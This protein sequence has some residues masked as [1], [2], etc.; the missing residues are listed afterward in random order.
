MK[1]ETIFLVALLGVLLLWPAAIARGDEI[2]DLKQQL[3]AQN[4]VLTE[5]QERIAQL[6]ARQKL[7]EQALTQKIDE[8]AQIA[9]K[10]EAITLPDS[11]KWAEKVKISGD[12]RYR[13]E[14]I[15]AE[16]NG[17]YQPGNNRNRI[18]ARLMLESIINDEW[19]VGFRIATGSSS[20]PATTNQNLDNG[21]TKKDIWLDL[22]YFDWHPKAI[23]RLNVF[24]GKML[25]PFY[26]AGNNQ[27]IWDD[28]V[29][30]EGIAAKYVIPFTKSDNL[31]VNGG[32]LWLKEDVGSAGGAGLWGAQTYLKHEFESKNY[33]LGG[34][35]FYAF[36]GLE[37]KSTLFSDSKGFGNTVETVGGKTFYTMDY[38]VFEG[39]GEYG[40]KIC[41]L[42]TTVYGNYVKNTSANTSE[43][44]GWLIGA[45]FNKAKDAGSWEL[46]Y[47]YRD[48]EKDAVLG[49]LTDS[50]FIGGGT[51]GKGH[52]F[53]GKYQLTKNIQAAL[54]YFLSE[55]LTNGSSYEKCD[56]YH[57]LMADLV[58]KF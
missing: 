9:E 22:A 21:F 8:V 18:R 27:L 44:A 49:V 30:P 40:F 39:F 41:E 32:G 50:D 7:K 12:L 45:T 25:L 19:G 29:N 24:G 36:S 37:G 1:K 43:D 31:Y 35:S 2:S 46:G 48:V 5:L 15:D 51:N 4:K 53:V 17:E 13:H 3:E 10:K 28:D 47:N 58:L 20:D 57:R 42:P 38:D 55:R 6:E 23:E 11:L 56:D 14:S 34:V 52:T 33:V 54:T 16:T 26:R